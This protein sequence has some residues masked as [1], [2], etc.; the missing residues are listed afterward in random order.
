MHVYIYREKNSLSNAF[1]PN[2]FA[3][4]LKILEQK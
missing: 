4:I 1:H 2:E 3:L